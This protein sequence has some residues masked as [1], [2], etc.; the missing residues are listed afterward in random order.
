M[1]H[2]VFDTL[3]V[4]SGMLGRLILVVMALVQ[5]IKET[6]KVSGVKAE[7]TS[8]VVGLL[9]GGAVSASY[10]EQLGWQATVSQWIGIAFFMVLAT[11]GPAG[12][13]KTLR[14]LLGNG[15]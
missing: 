1:E 13:Y 5:Y 9:A 6:W 3:S 4:L 7:V 15:S 8:L 12:G 2:T 10:L 11:I 14:T